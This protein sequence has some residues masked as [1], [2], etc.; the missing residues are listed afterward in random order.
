MMDSQRKIIYIG[1][2]KNLKNRITSYSNLHLLPRTEVMV[3]LINHI[4]WVI[5]KD[6]Q[7]ALLLE[8]DL[9]KHFKPR[10]NILLKDD[11]AFPFIKIE[12]TLNFPRITKIR[13]KNGTPDKNTFGPF[14]S[15]A[16]VEESIKAILSA[17]FKFAAALIILLKTVSSPVYCIK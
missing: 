9:I 12:N 2:A 17:C 16:N 6:E 15:A 14:A 7:D 8:S 11:K 4:E 13:S 5:T 1:K 3:G 10:Y